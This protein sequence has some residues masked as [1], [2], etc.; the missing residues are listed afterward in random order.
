MCGRAR[1]QRASLHRR[2]RSTSNEIS[3]T[4]LYKSKWQI[5]ASEFFVGR[6][7]FS[8]LST[9]TPNQMTLSIAKW[10]ESLF[11][12]HKFVS[13]HFCLL[14][15]LIEIFVFFF[16]FAE[17]SRVKCRPLSYSA[18][19]TFFV[20]LRNM[21][22]RLLASTLKINLAKL[23]QSHTF[24][25]NQHGFTCWVFFGVKISFVGLYSIEVGTINH[26]KLNFSNAYKI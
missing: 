20:D 15:C 6:V 23:W 16:Y 24:Q 2:A 5:T 13:K 12:G 26:L 18:S 10:H 21:I 1:V 3:V 7:N 25:M 9:A 8:S 11:P 19:V 4:I 17:V 22:C 14:N